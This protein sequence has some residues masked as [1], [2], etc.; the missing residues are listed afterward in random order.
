[1]SEFY[2]AR[3]NLRHFMA[4]LAPG[5]HFALQV[6]LP[7]AF[8]FWLF[9]P[10]ILFRAV[11][12]ALSCN[13]VPAVFAFIV[14][15]VLC[16]GMGAIVRLPPVLEVDDEAAE[17]HLRKPLNERFP[18]FRRSRDEF[19]FPNLRFRG[20]GQP[21]RRIWAWILGGRPQPMTCSQARA[22][23]ARLRTN[24]AAKRNP[25]IAALSK[26]LETGPE[27][28]DESL[29]D[30]LRRTAAG[31][32]AHLAEAPSTAVSPG[33]RARLKQESL[34]SAGKLEWLP[35][36]LWAADEH[37]YPLWLAYK[38][39]LRTASGHLADF[40]EF[41]WP[42]LLDTMRGK[43]SAAFPDN[44]PFQR[45]KILIRAQSLDLGN[46]VYEYEALVRMMAGFYRGLFWGLRLTLGLLAAA[47]VAAAAA[48]LC[49]GCLHHHADTVL[50]WAVLASVLLGLN[51]WLSRTILNN[52]RRL[53][54][55]E[56]ESVFDS[57][58]VVRRMGTSGEPMQSRTGE[59]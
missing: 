27:E 47:S 49:P 23:L 42:V 28:D 4:H 53:R 46:D 24:P 36:V 41:V 44:Q 30:W 55:A 43:V 6:F 25:L 21:L 39:Y 54:L 59:H 7:V 45:C 18:G 56:S 16:Y 15:V 40:E 58:A 8:L 38:T 26:A 51:I 9:F 5:G 3:F 35:S 32:L 11:S 57:Y 48:W 50:C 34:R 19:A 37:P 14:F 10:D 1:M 17:R 20:A 31:Q 13:A 33:D 22:L 2:P 12:L 52:F 29:R